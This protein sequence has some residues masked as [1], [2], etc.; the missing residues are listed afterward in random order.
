MC[1]FEYFWQIILALWGFF[2]KF[3]IPEYFPLVYSPGDQ[4]NF[5]CWERGWGAREWSWHRPGEYLPVPGEH[6]LVYSPGD[7]E[8]FSWGGGL[9]NE[10]DIDQENI[11]RYQENISWSV[12]IDQEMISWYQKNISWSIHQERN[13]PV[14]GAISLSRGRCGM[15]LQM[16]T[17]QFG[18]HFGTWLINKGNF[19]VY[20]CHSS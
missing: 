19:S 17:K 8:I 9:G 6:L 7:Q 18:F 11:S 20:G 3:L 5:S 14:R 10:V 13:L 16:H 1:F 12:L 2:T 15:Y 4:E